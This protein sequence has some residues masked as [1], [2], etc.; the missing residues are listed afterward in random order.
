MMAK[1]SAVVPLAILLYL[2]ASVAAKSTDR[3]ETETTDFGQD[4]ELGA[5]PDDGSVETALLNYLFAKQI[6]ARL[7][8]NANPQDLM[9][10]RSYWKQCAFNAVS[11]FGK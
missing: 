10:K 1:I 9:R 5:V 6:V 7:R 2:A 11:C 3:E 4:I 8:T